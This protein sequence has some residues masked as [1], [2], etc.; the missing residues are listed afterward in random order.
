[1]LNRRRTTPRDILLAI[2]IGLALAAL[3]GHESYEA[4]DSP[5]E[6]AQR[7][8]EAIDQCREV[9]GLDARIKFSREG[10]LIC[11]RAGGGA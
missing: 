6:H 4:P 2:V 3:A 8:R 9:Y 10:H 11:R 5:E 7:R 1:M